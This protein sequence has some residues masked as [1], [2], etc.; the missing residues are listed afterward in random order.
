MGRPAWPRYIASLHVLVAVTALLAAWPA[1]AGPP[2]R[3]AVAPSAAP[4]VEGRI[5]ALPADNL[6]VTDIQVSRLRAA[7]IVEGEVL[8][9]E[10][11]ASP[12][13]GRFVGPDE[14][15]RLLTDHAAWAAADVDVLCFETGDRTLAITAA[16]AP[17][18]DLV[19]TPGHRRVLVSKP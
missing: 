16:G 10:V 19:R 8:N 1:A 11:G 4:V 18:A 2:G 14:L 15:Q 7:R 12:M 3:P 13:R 6:L 9:V 17:L 5:V